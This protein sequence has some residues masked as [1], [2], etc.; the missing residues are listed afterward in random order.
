MMQGRARQ[1]PMKMVGR[2]NQRL[3]RRSSDAINMAWTANATWTSFR[4]V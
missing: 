4:A 3:C 1:H 2:F